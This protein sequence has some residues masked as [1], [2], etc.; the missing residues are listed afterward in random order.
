M[1]SQV[2]NRITQV[3]SF[4]ASR[5]PLLGAC[6]RIFTSLTAGAQRTGASGSV[7]RSATVAPAVEHQAALVTLTTSNFGTLVEGASGVALVDFWAPWCMPCRLV[8]PAIERLADEFSGRVTV[9]KLN[10]DEH[11]DIASRYQIT[12]IPTVGIFRDGELVNQ[13]VGVRTEQI[14]RKELQSAL[15]S[16][17][18]DAADVAASSVPAAQ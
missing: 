5:C 3:A 17:M 2:W 11:M 6:H 14:Y 13:L 16:A 7:P 15:D 1:R 10:V 18:S 4:V 9:G 12:S 8:G